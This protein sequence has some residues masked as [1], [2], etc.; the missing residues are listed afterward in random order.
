M[1]GLLV[2]K[3]DSL[4]SD[5]NIRVPNQTTLTSS[6]WSS[7]SPIYRPPTDNKLHDDCLA[8]LAAVKYLVEEEE[9]RASGQLVKE[10]VVAEFGFATAV[11]G[12]YLSSVPT[13]RTMNVHLLLD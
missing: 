2:I 10:G 6:Q 11:T 4:G 3:L 9:E 12:H 13:R 8:Q 5:I 1:T 7:S